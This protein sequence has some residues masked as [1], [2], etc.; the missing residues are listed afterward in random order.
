MPAIPQSWSA[1]RARLS[2]SIT[3]TTATAASCWQAAC[4]P[5]ARMLPPGGQ[6]PQAHL[7]QSVRLAGGAHRRSAREI[8]RFSVA[9]IPSSYDLFWSF[10]GQW[11]RKQHWGSSVAPPVVASGEPPGRGS[12]IGEPRQSVGSDAP[13]LLL[14]VGN[15]SA[16]LASVT[17]RAAHG[18][19][20]AL[21]H[22]IR[23]GRHIGASACVRR[24]TAPR[25]KDRL[26]AAPADEAVRPAA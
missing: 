8:A 26:H 14:P 7:L 5:A 3:S 6:D 16:G 18:V 4:H 10:R 2:W 25:R 22:R 24:P 21:L 11:H 15:H 12:S 9:R 1:P 17:R 19:A 20:A 13:G 23:S